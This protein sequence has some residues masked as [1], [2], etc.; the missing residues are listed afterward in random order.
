M[1]NANVSYYD[2]QNPCYVKRRINN[3]HPTLKL[4]FQ[5]HESFSFIRQ[6]SKYLDFF[7]FSKAGFRDQRSQFEKKNFEKYF[8][9]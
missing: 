8:F 9:Y 2:F 3:D 6:E 4:Y 1:D 5:L 7:V